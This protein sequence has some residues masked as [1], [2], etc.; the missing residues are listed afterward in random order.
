MGTWA[1][2]KHILC[3]IPTPWLITEPKGQDH[4]QGV[5]RHPQVRPW[6]P[7][8]SSI[9]SWGVSRHLPHINAYC[10]TTEPVGPIIDPLGTVVPTFHAEC[11]NNGAM[12]LGRVPRCSSCLIGSILHSEHTGS[13]THIH[14]PTTEPVVR[15]C[16]CV[17]YIDNIG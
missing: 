12:R 10:G 14:G 13:L 16:S 11:G 4:A 3:T 1:C 7:G 6:R 5:L 9:G 2:Q 17:H 15:Q 8:T